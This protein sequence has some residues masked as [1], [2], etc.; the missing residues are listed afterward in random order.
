MGFVPLQAPFTLRHKVK[1]HGHSV[2]VQFHFDL[3]RPILLDDFFQQIDVACEGFFPGGC[4]RAS[5][6]RPIV[7]KGFRDGHVSGFLER[8]DMRREISIRH[9]QSIAHFG[10]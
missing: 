2:F 8:T 3:L 1:D 5:R 10:E 7:L 9:L 6:Q 4:E